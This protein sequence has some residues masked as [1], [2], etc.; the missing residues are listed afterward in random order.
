MSRAEGVSRAGGMLRLAVI[1]GGENSEHD[2]SL[3]SAAGVA[4]AAIE[5]GF[6]VVGLTIGRDGTWATA[7]GAPIG[8]ED[9]VRILRSCDVAFPALHGVNGEDGLL[10][11]FLTAIGVPYVGSD[12]PAGVLGMD[13]WVTKLI[14]E[15]VGVAT[16]PGVL[17]R[18]G[19]RPSSALP[20]VPVV[21]KPVAAGSSHGVTFVGDAALIDLAVVAALEHDDRVLVEKAVVGR[22]V[23]IAVIERADGALTVSPP[24]EIDLGGEDVFGT[25]RKYGGT[26]RF[27]VPA[28]VSDS[29]RVEMESA[30]RTLFRAL[31]C[32]GVARFDFFVTDSGIVLN[33]VNTMPGFTAQSQVPQ[34][35][36]AAGWS[37]ARLVGELVEVAL[38]G[39][40]VRP[41]RG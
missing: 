27:A 17:V 24:L 18:A 1:G 28:P 9:A 41:V 39:A 40:V 22:E 15:A 10:A 20:A 34:M 35:F 23:D 2:V 30:A 16:A 26:A 32:R 13:K 3:A 25:E 33:E 12:M 4:S 29:V 31:G 6:T 5:C 7:A 36:E 37:Y 14:A 11:A 38:A 8:V 19:T 21:V